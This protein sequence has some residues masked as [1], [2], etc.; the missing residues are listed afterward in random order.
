MPPKS[1]SI[2]H[3]SSPLIKTLQSLSVLDSALPHSRFV[4]T[5]GQFIDFSEAFTLAGFLGV[6]AGKVGTPLDIVSSDTD[7]SGGGNSKT[8]QAQT[9]YLTAR[10]EMMAFIVAS[11]PTANTQDQRSGGL[12]LPR[13]GDDNFNEDDRG[14]SAYLRFYRLQQSE[15]EAR[16]LQ[17]HTRIRRD[18]TAQSSSLAQ[19]AALDGKLNEIL[20]SYSRQAL[21]VIPSLL[22][23]RFHYLSNESQGISTLEQ[24]TGQ[25]AITESDHVLLAFLREMQTVLLAELDIRLQPTLGLIEALAIEEEENIK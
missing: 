9:R 23:K 14:L 5:V 4:A 18:L 13:V 21:A 12:R 11:F 2:T 16:I 24:E 6:N 3:P 20:S 8:T 10:G 7:A 19:L 22:R 17:L 15:M 1:L 25:E